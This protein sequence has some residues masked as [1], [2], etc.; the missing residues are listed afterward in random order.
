VEGTLDEINFSVPWSTLTQDSC[1]IQIKG[2]RITIQPKN[3]T[4]NGSSMIDSMFTSMASSMQLAEEC[5]KKCEDIEEEQDEDNQDISGL[6][7]C[8][9]TI[10][11][12]NAQQNLRE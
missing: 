5:L 1:E 9:K 11:A 4:D 8:A 6:E 3:R 10:D 7:S 12:S 2:L